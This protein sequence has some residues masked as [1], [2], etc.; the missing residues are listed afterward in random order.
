M[1]KELKPRTGMR[2]KI[3]QEIVTQVVS[4][5]TG[6]ITESRTHKEFSI[7]R[8][9]DYIKLYIKDIL[10]L[11]DLSKG[12]NDI[13]YSLLKRM[14]Y[15]DNG[16]NLLY[17]FAPI[18]R[19][20]AAELGLKEGT[21]RKAIEQL[22]EK[23]ILIRKDRGTYMVN[24]FLFGRGKWEDIRKIRLQVEYSADGGKVFL[25]TEFIPKEQEELE[26]ISAN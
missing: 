3:N 16:E 4:S 23:Q 18:K 8:E 13:M 9:P 12:T 7:E 14:T 1:I 6:E 15:A 5:E 17:L 22:T 26:E 24:P 20:V 10:R 11:K 25:E 19:A 21:I 2:R